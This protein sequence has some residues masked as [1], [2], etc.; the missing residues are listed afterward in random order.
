MRRASVVTGVLLLFATVLG[1]GTLAEA[2][3]G[4]GGSS[5]SRGSRS[6]S[7]PRA[8]ASPFSPS[9]PS[10]Q[11]APAPGAPQRPG[12]L[13]GGFGGMLGGLLLGGLLGSL[14]FG[15]GLGAGMG[16]GLLEILLVA[17]LAFVAIQFFRR[18]APQPA[19]ASG[20][21]LSGYGST[22]WAPAE[23][24]TTPGSAAVATAGGDLEQG[25]A[26][27]RVMDAAFDPARFTETAT[28]LF[29]RVQAAWGAR[30]LSLVRA[31]L[32]EEMATTFETDLN[33]LRTLHRVNRLE[34]VSVQS[35]ELTE[36]W[37]E[38]GRD[39]ATVR[40]RATALDYTLDETTGAVVEGSQTA[41]TS[42]EEYWTFARPVGPSPWRLSAIQQ[43]TA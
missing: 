3:I 24:A 43:P 14:L 22:G 6:Y 36:A 16:F 21:S 26:A 23:P 38:Y 2:R 10:R 4:G 31:Q 42:F 12:G 37:Q 13:F 9:S 28:D 35:A 40:V 25:I 29:L 33:R 20:P 18:R 30:D 17:G 8:P 41:P 5:G 1:L 32:T 19:P 11:N 15:G 27:I 7:A 34:R 39:F